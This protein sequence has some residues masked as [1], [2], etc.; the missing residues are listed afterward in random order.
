MAD[1]TYD[2][3]NKDQMSIVVRYVADNTPVERFLFLTVIEDKC[4]DGQAKEVLGCLNGHDIHA[5]ML[6]FQSYD[7]TACMYGE[8]NG[9]CSSNFMFLKQKYLNCKSPIK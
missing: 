2:V 5:E 7:F 3:S 4:G 9:C 6:Y 8:Y 1:T